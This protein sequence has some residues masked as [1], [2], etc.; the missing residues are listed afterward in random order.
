MR[1]A[2]TGG[3]VRPISRGGVC[4]LLLMPTGGRSARQGR[5]RRRRRRCRACPHGAAR[6]DS[7]Q[8]QCAP[9]TRAAGSFLSRLLGERNASTSRSQSGPV[10]SDAGQLG[11]S[12]T[13]CVA[14]FPEHVV[15]LYVLALFELRPVPNGRDGLRSRDRVEAPQQGS[16]SGSARYRSDSFNG[17]LELGGGWLVGI[18]LLLLRRCG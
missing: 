8:V 10:A 7:T 11:G 18:Q 15:L 14:A 2:G 6:Q 5:R 16:G 3:A 17:S 1:S 12:V 4:R 9:E 13:A